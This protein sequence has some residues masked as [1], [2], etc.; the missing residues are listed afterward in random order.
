MVLKSVIFFTSMEV[1]KQQKV[2]GN[3]KKKI[4]FRMIDEMDK[5]WQNKIEEW[6]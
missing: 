4:S 1:L 3:I 6:L 2:S 5:Q